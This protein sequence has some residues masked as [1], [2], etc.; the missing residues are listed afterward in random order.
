MR[1]VVTGASGQVGRSLIR[2]APSHI[3]LH[4]WKH[5]DLDI[6]NEDQVC[7]TLN[8]CRPDLIINAAAFT[9]VDQ[10]E[11]DSDTAYRVNMNAVE[12][13]AR[14]ARQ[15]GSRMIHLSTDYVF[16]GSLSRPYRPTDATS[17]LGVYGESKRLGE[18]RAMEQLPDR[19][20]ILRS[21]WIYSAGAK[22]FVTKILK[23]ASDRDT[24]HVVCDQIGS[25]TW[26][27]SL[28]HAIWA[29]A[30]HTHINGVYHW[31]DA[32]V[33]S[34]YDFAFAII[35]EATRLGLTSPNIE[36]QP[37]YTEFHQTAARRPSYSVLDL[38]DASRLLTLSPRHWRVQLRAM[39][40]ELRDA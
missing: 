30:N 1:V 6:C 3:E 37:V 22:N 14:T 11:V 9:N 18:L 25:P 2:T 16:D 4:A 24:L 12:C 40:S 33:A 13:L 21:A 27:P 26:A 35:E 20:V 7:E 32:G 29:T 15:V 5:S 8:A 19:L 23:A 17:P 39:L 28:A 36:I 38:R 34:R 10:A 31:A